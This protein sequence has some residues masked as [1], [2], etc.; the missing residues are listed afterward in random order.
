MGSASVFW[1]LLAGIRGDLTDGFLR[2]S[3]MIQQRCVCVSEE[4]ASQEHMLRNRA[5]NKPSDLCRAVE[6]LKT[7]EAQI[8]FSRSLLVSLT[9]KRQMGM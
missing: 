1:K 4:E 6:T 9:D 8:Y 7:T 2:E 3:T 5:R